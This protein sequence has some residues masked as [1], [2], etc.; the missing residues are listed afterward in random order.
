MQSAACSIKNQW[1]PATVVKVPPTHDLEIFNSHF[2]DNYM[3]MQSRI[4]HLETVNCTKLCT[5]RVA[6][7][8]GWG[9]KY[10]RQVKF[11]FFTQCIYFFLQMIFSRTFFIS[12]PLI[13]ELKIQ[14]L[15]RRFPMRKIGAFRSLRSDCTRLR[16]RRMSF[17]VSKGRAAVFLSAGASVKSHVVSQLKSPNFTNCT[18]F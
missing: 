3:T 2:F 12:L 7:V 13:F 4:G 6:F 17:M 11:F 9:E 10:R 1:H 5:I 18:I 16:H 15:T 8:K 14:C